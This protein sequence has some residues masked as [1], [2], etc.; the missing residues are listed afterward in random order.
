MLAS[1]LTRMVTGAHQ[2]V[3]VMTVM[4]KCCFVMAIHA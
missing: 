4:L 2:Y 3:M 1:P